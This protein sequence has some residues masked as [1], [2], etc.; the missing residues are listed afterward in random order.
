[1]AVALVSQA[2]QPRTSQ[3]R[4]GVTLKQLDVVVNGADGRHVEGLTVDDFVVSEDDVPARVTFVTEVKAPAT[5]VTERSS[6][7]SGSDSDVWTNANVPD[8]IFAIVLDDLSTRATD[9]PKARAV[10]RRFIDQLLPG[11]MAAVVFTGQ[12]AGAQEFTA[13][14]GRLR[15]ALNHYSGRFA[16]PEFD[17][18]SEPSALD[19]SMKATLGG[20]VAGNLARTV[21]TLSNVAEWLAPVSKRRKAILFVTAGLEPAAARALLAGLDQDGHARGDLANSFRRLLSSA[22]SAHVSIYPLDYRGLSGP[23]GPEAVEQSGLGS[24]AALQALASETGGVAYVNSNALDGF[25]S[26]VFQDASA[27]YLVSYEA[28]PNQEAAATSVSVRARRA[29]V[30]VRT[31]RHNVSPPKERRDGSREEMSRMLS[32]PLPVGD[33][34]MRAHVVTLPRENGRGRAFVLL[35]VSGADLPLANDRRR[36]ANL[37]YRIVAT[38]VD[39]KIRASESKALDLRLS[40]QRSMQLASKELRIVSHLDLPAGVFRVR[41]SVVT[42]GHVGTILGDLEVPAYDT[43]PLV[44]SAPLVVAASAA[45]TPVRREDFE[46]FSRRLPA[47]PTTRRSFQSGDSLVAYVEA[48]VR[49]TRGDVAPSPEVSVSVEG[50]AGD[51]VASPE[52]SVGARGR[53]LAGGTVYPVAARLSLDRLTAGPYTLRIVTTLARLARVV[54][55]AAFDVQ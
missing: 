28:A 51:I 55:T 9:T 3:F 38:D 44:V 14:K 54:R 30:T 13:D 34:A 47:A 48:H 42:G 41:A 24:G 23:L 5:V 53:G 29:A 18:V 39:G 36:D 43:A 50:P 45:S 20:E 10:A 31:R 27:Y 26:R 4:S 21:A 22:A 25:V 2:A 49:P 15:G 6:S 52:I 8:R 12:Q 19:R 46:L 32:S 7:V 37:S 35:D 16:A 1:M 33:I 40:E 17:L 11:D